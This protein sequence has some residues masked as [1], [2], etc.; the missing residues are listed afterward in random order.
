MTRPGD[1][2]HCG[3]PM[4]CEAD[5]SLRR[6]A[7]RYRWLRS[8][9]HLADAAAVQWWGGVDAAL[10]EGEGLDN[11]IDAAIDRSRS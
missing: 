9:G 6:D 1:C 2:V 4:H 11:A 8:A 10:R 5:E 3:E 7:E